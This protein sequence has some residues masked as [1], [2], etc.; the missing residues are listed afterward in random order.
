MSNY[1]A[2]QP[3]CTSKNVFELLSPP[4][5]SLS[6][7]KEPQRK[8]RHKF[9]EKMRWNCFYWKV[10]FLRKKKKSPV[11]KAKMFCK[12]YFE[13]AWDPIRMAGEVQS[14]LARPSQQKKGRA[15]NQ[16]R[17]ESWGLSFMLQKIWKDYF[18]CQHKN[19]S[20]LQ[21]MVTRHS[22]SFTSSSTIRQVWVCFVFPFQVVELIVWVTTIITPP[23]NTYLY[24]SLPTATYT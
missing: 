20:K 24:Q 16:S 7:A 21:N 10:C 14:R 12:S 2:Q 8:V 3:C 6:V 5:S 4:P 1:A 19:I 9:T 22:C 17:P 15:C 23:V 13:F 11:A 18:S